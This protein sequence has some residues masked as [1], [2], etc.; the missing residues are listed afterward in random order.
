MVEKNL[1]KA[2][3]LMLPVLLFSLFVTSCGDGGSRRNFKIEGVNGPYINIVDDSIQITIHF[4]KLKTQGGGRF[5]IDG[6]NSESSY[7]EVSPVFPGS[8]PD[9]ITTLEG[10][11]L[12]VH[13]DARDVLSEDFDL[14]EGGTLPGGRPLPGGLARLPSYGFEFKNE[15]AVF[16]F[17]NKIAGIFFPLDLDLEGTMLSFSHYV[18]L[19]TGGTKKVGTLTLVSN[20]DSGKNGGVLLLLDIDQQTKSMLKRVAKSRN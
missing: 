18:D 12:I 6:S 13:L 7:I 2:K 3:W 17:G 16:Y 11:L 14:I 5:P 15:D 19:P 8:L 9:D 1:V 10:T 4:E 20:D